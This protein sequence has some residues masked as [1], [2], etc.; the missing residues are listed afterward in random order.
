ML[1]DVPA[2]Q[3]QQ[4]AGKVLY[5]DPGQDEETTL[6]DDPRKIAGP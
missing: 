5:L 1:G 4:V 3:G 6:V 2:A